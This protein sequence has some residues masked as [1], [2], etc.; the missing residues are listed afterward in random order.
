MI[1][2][3]TKN[4]SANGVQGLLIATKQINFNYFFLFLSFLWGSK[5]GYAKSILNYRTTLFCTALI[6]V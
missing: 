2:Y 4:I 1:Q 6:K 5:W 3:K